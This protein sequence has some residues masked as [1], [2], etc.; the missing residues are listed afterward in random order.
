MASTPLVPGA[1]ALRLV[2]RAGSRGHHLRGGEALRDHGH[3]VERGVRRR[4]ELRELLLQL[5]PG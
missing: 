3:A 4:R 1:A 2:R 5:H